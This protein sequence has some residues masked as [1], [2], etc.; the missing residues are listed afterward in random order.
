MARLN[1]DR[2]GSIYNSIQNPNRE[3][4]LAPDALNRLAVHHPSR[5]RGNMNKLLHLAV[6]TV[7]HISNERHVRHSRM[8]SLKRPRQADPYLTSSILRVLWQR[9]F[10][11]PRDFFEVSG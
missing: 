2:K 6:W 9:G 1:S 3:V 7:N 5:M 4:F 11:V 8:L 10:R